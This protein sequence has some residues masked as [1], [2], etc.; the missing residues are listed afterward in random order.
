MIRNYK[1]LVK[2]LWVGLQEADRA[3]DELT[4]K[5]KSTITTG[6][7]VLSVIIAGTSVFAGL[8]DENPEM[9]IAS[10]VSIYGITV[11]IAWFGF[12]GFMFILAS[13][14]T[15]VC[16]LAIVKLE[17]PFSSKLVISG[18]ATNE[19]KVEA[20]ESILEGKI[21]KKIHEAY[22]KALRSRERIIKKVGRIALAGQIVLVC[23]TSAV[24]HCAHECHL[25]KN[26]AHIATGQQSPTRA[27]FSGQVLVGRNAH[28]TVPKGITP[29]AS[30]TLL[31]S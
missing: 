26:H 17:N 11:S 9:L 13:M 19:E 20:W 8:L 25:C 12:F 14:C 1:L 16:A 2:M 22:A 18:N 24:L 21:Y 6:A 3:I 4:G 28:P 29:R 30:R 27:V 23:R 31:A 7:V 10:Q 15:S 5:A